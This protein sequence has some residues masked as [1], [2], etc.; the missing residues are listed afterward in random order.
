[1][2]LLPTLTE[3]TKEGV[4]AYESMQRSKGWQF[5]QSILQL[6]RGRLLEVLLSK[7]FTQKTAHEKDVLQRAYHEIDRIITFLLDP[8][9]EFRQ[10]NK[11]KDHNM[12]MDLKKLTKE[13]ING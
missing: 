1:M 8:L 5:H 7:G 3:I 9:Q 11:W 13:K 2:R 10:G 4:D 6:C 12:K